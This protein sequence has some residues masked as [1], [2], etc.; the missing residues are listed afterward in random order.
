MNA[1]PRIAV[2]GATGLVGQT[3]LDVLRSATSPP[4]RSSPS[5]RRDRPAATWT[6]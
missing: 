1:T 6:E 2:V 3:M 5:P 4:R